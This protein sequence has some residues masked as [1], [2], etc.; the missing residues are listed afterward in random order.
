MLA[1]TAYYCFIDRTGPL[2]PY[3]C[4]GK[5]IPRLIDLWLDLD[6]VFTHGL[7]TD[8]LLTMMDS[9]NELEDDDV[10]IDKYFIIFYYKCAYN[11]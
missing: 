7:T 1:L 2:A 10:E 4:A 6:L 3:I 8:G 11:C 5:L 9:D